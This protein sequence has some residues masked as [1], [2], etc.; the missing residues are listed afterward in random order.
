MA[1]ENKLINKVKRL[2]R[3][4]GLPRWLHRFGP[5]K[6]EFWHHGLALIMKQECRLGYHRVT[7]LL[8]G[9]G[10]KTP[11]PSALC[12]SFHKMPLQIW[13]RL[14]EAT[15]M[16]KVYIA[17]IDG[18]GMSRSLPSPY[19]VKRIDKPY[20]VEV[21]LKTSLIINTKNKKILAI[22]LRAKSAH[23]LK[24]QNTF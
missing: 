12:T 1:S 20:P 14:L 18:S 21:P 16:Q 24:M 8:R 9:L 15:A 6:Y 13:Q 22:R 23:S 10:H 5:K 4:A 19:Y 17:A 11:C 3:R 7:R 2:I